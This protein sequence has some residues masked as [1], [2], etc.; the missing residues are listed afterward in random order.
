MPACRPNHPRAATTGRI[1][2]AA[3]ALSQAQGFFRE[4]QFL[5]TDCQTPMDFIQ[6]R[7]LPQYRQAGLM[8][9]LPLGS[10]SFE[11]QGQ[12]GQRRIAEGMP[13]P[14]NLVVKKPPSSKPPEACFKSGHC[15]W[16]AV[17]EQS[18]QIRK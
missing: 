16:S 6:F 10:P 9:I 2:C 7:A 12:P 14:T 1:A 15:P 11:I 5:G 17:G 13:K 8:V 4:R 3:A 18:D